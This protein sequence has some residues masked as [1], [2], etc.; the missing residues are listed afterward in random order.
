[1]VFAQGAETFPAKALNMSDDGANRPIIILR[2]KVSKEDGHHGGAWK[3][4]MTSLSYGLPGAFRAAFHKGAG[5]PE[6]ASF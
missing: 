3:V 2:K 1:M 4:A 6:F 5:A